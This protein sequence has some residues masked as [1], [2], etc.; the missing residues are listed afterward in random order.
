MYP[1]IETI[2]IEDGKIYNLPYHNEWMNRTRSEV[3]GVMD[4]NLDLS[5]YIH[6]EAY[7]ERTKCRVEYLKD[8]V[9]VEYFTYYVRPVRSLQLVVCDDA[10]YRYKSTDRHLLNDLYA[11]R[12][13]RDD[14]LI[15]RNGLL[16]DTSICNVALWN[17]ESWLTPARPLLQGTKRASLL[18]SGMITSKDITAKELREYSSIRLFNALIDFG[19]IEMDMTSVVI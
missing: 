3:L 19:E 7:G 15:V 1:F 11:Q 5:D 16:T 12:M 10:D 9:K 6:P 17:G 2:R 13:G 14:V 8:I 4:C 18:D